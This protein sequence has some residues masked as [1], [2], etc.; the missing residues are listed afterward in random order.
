MAFDVADP[1]YQDLLRRVLQ[2]GARVVPFVGAGLSVYGDPQQRLPLW[3][4][5]LERLV[6]EG[7]QLGL[8]PDD[9]DPRI[10]AALDD[11]RYIEAAD[12]ILDALGEPTF[13]R[14]VEREL[15]DTG[16]PTPPAIT[17]LVAIGWSL[18]VTTNLDRLIA[19]AY[20]EQ[21]GRPIRTISN[22]DTHKLASALAGTLTAPETAL[23]Q[24]HGDIDIYPSWR[25][26]P[27]HYEQLLRDPGY[28][29]ALK[30]LFL[31]QVF[32]VGFG[33]QD[34]DF[35]FLLETIARIYPA[36][37]GEFYALIERSRSDDPVIHHLIR[38]SGLRP[39]YYDIEDPKDVSDPFGGHRAVYE[40]LGHLAV[41]RTTT[42]AG[43]A[44]T[45]KYFPELDPS[46]VGREAEIERLSALLESEQGRVVQVLGLGGVGKTS[47]V[48]QYLVDQRPQ[49]ARAGY[50]CAFG[51]SFY[52]SDIGDFIN[53]MA[54]AI[55]GPRACSLSQQVERICDRVRQH[56][57]LLVLDGLE[58]VL[59]TD[60]GL[61]SPYLVQIIDG[62]LQGHG[63]VILTS[64]VPARG[65]ILEH[66]PQIA[67]GPLSDDQVSEFLDRW[68]LHDLGETPR[69][70][71][72]DV[73]AGH[74]LALRILAGVLRDV[75]AAEA[76]RT[77]E[78]SAVIDLSDEVDPLRENRLARILGSYVQHLQKEEIAFLTSWTAFDTPASYPLVERALTRDYP[79]TEANASLVGLDLRVIVNALLER[80]LLTTDSKGELSSHPTVR[81]YFARLARD[82]GLSLVP[83]HRFLASEY[84]HGTVRLPESFEQASPLLIAARHAAA[85]EDWTLFDDLF[86]HRLMRGFRN[87]LC[88]NLGAWE[89]GLTLARLG[90]ESSFPADQSAEPAFFP[91]TVA[92]CLKHLGRTSESRAKYLQTLTGI[93]PLRESDTAKYVNNLLTLLIWR[94]ELEGAHRLVELNIRALSWITEPW[95]H[96]WQVEHG[97]STFAYL[98]MLQGDLESASMLFEFAAHAWDGYEGQRLWVYD[99]YPYHRSELVLMA[100]PEGHEHSLAGIESLLTVA[101]AQGWPESICRGHIQAATVYLDWASRTGD[102]AKLN[103]AEHR[104]EQARLT[105]SGM[106]IPD[107]AITHLLARVRAELVRCSLHGDLRLDRTELKSLVRRVELLVESSGLALSTSETMAANGAIALL[108]GATESARHSYDQALQRCHE[109]GNVLSPA[110]PRSLVNYLGR[111]LGATVT[112]DPPPAREDPILLLSEELGSE[113]MT[114]R[115]KELEDG[116]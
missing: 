71:L 67:L 35:D 88:N 6:A 15:D 30:H 45:L 73:T 78:R 44:I 58:A 31:R 91:I 43:F 106:S 3:S 84:L 96:R 76:T 101:Q 48:Q 82:S 114:A 79:D 54:L 32:F 65:G 59:D 116:V 108:A 18:I 98:R 75:P 51:C 94:G 110:S 8:I 68:G 100:N 74:P 61:R 25:L 64:R 80:R 12:R 5:L 34:A 2:T 37:V 77:I 16:K 90:D 19:R 97:F 7:K 22:L 109:Q 10:D 69:R 95:K 49:L 112:L 55:V 89:E 83:I 99:Y 70:R 27:S 115:L 46:L 40:C 56:R 39:I 102:P 24:I 52:R 60:C 63:G 47:L 38:S 66:A 1:T 23:A 85:C 21:H 28:T 4:E 26:T 92:R 29:E 72:M 11:G 62:V 42:S 14:V 13:R 107:V 113:W 57:T 104:L 53:D 50:K 86:R 111:R 41:S 17:E 33:L 105:T 103:L 81:E 87:H 20:L 36:G 9:G 93:A